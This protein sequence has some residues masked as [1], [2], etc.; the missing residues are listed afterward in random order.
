[1]ETVSVA[2]PSTIALYYNDI[3][4]KYA[5]EGKADRAREILDQSLEVAR[6]IEDTRNKV[7]TMGAIAAGK[8]PDGHVV[9]YFTTDRLRSKIL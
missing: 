3:A 5:K 4:I 8:I 1:M 9:L 6:T 2:A 7:T